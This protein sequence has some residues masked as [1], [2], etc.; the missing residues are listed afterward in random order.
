MYLSYAM[1]SQVNVRLESS[2]LQR[3]PVSIAWQM[4]VSQK[5]KNYR[6]ARTYSQNTTTEE[7]SVIRR[8]RPEVVRELKMEPGGTGMRYEISAKPPTR[9][10]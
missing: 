8:S 5:K 2:S 9:L 10:K 7:F 4:S 1:S 3:G 6:T